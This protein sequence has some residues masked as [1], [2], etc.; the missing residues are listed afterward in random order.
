MKRVV[1]AILIGLASVNV[2][3]NQTVPGEFILQLKSESDQKKIKSLVQEG[4]ARGV[5][6]D[7]GVYLIK[8]PVVETAAAA[9]E[10][11]QGLLDVE[12]VEPNY[13]WRA[14]R[15]PISNDSDVD[16]LWGM[17][18]Y[19]QYEPKNSQPNH[20]PKRGV[21]GID[22]EASSAWSVT[23]GLHQ[24]VVGIIDTGIDFKHEDLK[25]NIWINELEKNGKTGVDDDGNGYVDDVHGWDFANNIANGFDDQGHGTHCAGT[26]GAIGDNKKGVV[27]V[28]PV[29][30]MMAIKF[31]D[32]NGSGTTEG[33]IKSIDYSVKM[34][35]HLTS[36]SWGGGGFSQALFDAIK[37][38]QTAGQL[39]VAAAGNNGKNTD[40]SVNYPSGYNLDNIISVG[41]IDNRGRL[42]TFSNYGKTTVDLAAPGVNILSTTPG[43]NYEVYSGTSM[44]TPHVS[45]AA[46][47]LWSTKTAT[48]Q[49]IKSRL[50]GS[51]REI[52]ALKSK[53]ASGGMLNV[54][55]ALQGTKP[56]MLDSDP[57][58]W[59]HVN[60]SL[61]T[62]HPYTAKLDTTYE[63]RVP[64]AKKIA[65][66]FDRFEVEGMFGGQVYDFVEFMDEAGVVV[67]T[68][69]G[70][71]D[72]EYS[73]TVEGEVIKIRLKTDELYHLYGFDIT[74]VAV[75]Y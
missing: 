54:Y 16:K 50:I 47:L 35:V 19:G 70:N 48:Y 56:A 75:T 66:Y 37:R 43:N 7:Y 63:V 31:L 42:A 25:E 41:A 17:E 5:L 44:A 34:K 65:V 69:Y 40:V 6:E 53:T 32:K 3:A 33:A 39:F 22:I 74:K 4:V 49:E 11:I 13:I 67:G 30:K 2:Y 38:A 36:N 64:G 27:G 12:Y 24:I 73:E 60:K 29:V 1:G 26:I 68:F 23:K 18:N 9:I 8:R 21:S 61:S 52:S 51:V 72:Q 45:G 71:H 46:A 55:H 28:A 57:L 59:T 62:P 10:K 14:S 20:V 15:N 58:N